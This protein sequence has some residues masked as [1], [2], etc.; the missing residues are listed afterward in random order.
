M[1]LGLGT[2]LGTSGVLGQDRAATRPDVG[3][4]EASGPET[5]RPGNSVS[6]P[7]WNEGRRSTD[8]DVSSP[9]AEIREVP[10]A[11][12]QAVHARY[13]WY[14]A[15]TDLYNT[16]RL[17]IQ[18]YNSSPEYKAALL[19]QSEAWDAYAL[20]RTKTVEGLI[21]DPAYSANQMLR[22]KL[23]NQIADAYEAPRPDTS[24]IHAMSSLKLNFAAQNR[25]LET[26]LL[27]RDTDY[28]SAQQHYRAAAAK[29]RE[30]DEKR[31]MMI[32]T[33]PTLSAMRQAIAQAHIDTMTTS[34]YLDSA[35]RARDI[36]IDY[37]NERDRIRYRYNYPG[38]YDYPDTGYSYPYG[39]KYR[40]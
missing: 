12:A 29:V 27:D 4:L 25:K 16:L 37:A 14:Q 26:S 8:S 19:E 7:Y 32:A 23:S 18:E 9:S 6:S 20:A 33:D 2:A 28:K 3:R 5:A 13:S 39:Y 36:A 17:K 11:R 10:A 35:L 30:L 34:A 1:V 24:A 21:K 40:R 15:Q 38:I 31:A 22:E